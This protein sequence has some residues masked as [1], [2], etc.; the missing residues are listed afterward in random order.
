MYL[1]SKVEIPVDFFSPTAPNI[2]PHN[3]DNHI[4][5]TE[6]S[7]FWSRLKLR[8][9]KLDYF[10]RVFA[11]VYVVLAAGVI[12]YLDLQEVDE[13]YLL[14]LGAILVFILVVS[15]YSLNYWSRCRRRVFIEKENRERWIAR[16]ISW[17]IVYKKFRIN[18][19]LK[20][21]SHRVILELSICLTPYSPPI[22]EAKTET[23]ISMPALH[24]KSNLSSFG[25]KQIESQKV[26]LVSSF[27][28]KLK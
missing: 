11:V 17:K 10:I 5:Q 9:Y 22:I 1:S 26:Y 20:K 24:F 14:L 3:I 27:F 19:K 28:S 4:T 23:R 6:F 2:L 15:I 7:E 13:N 21:P 16:G 12:L 25:S 18:K 8:S